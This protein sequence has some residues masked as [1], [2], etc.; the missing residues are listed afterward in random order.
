MTDYYE[1][2]AR[3]VLHLEGAV[4]NGRT[5]LL[6]EL[7]GAAALSPYHF[8][9]IWRLATGE[10]LG[11]TIRRVRLGH[12]LP[13]LPKR[14]LA[15]ATDRSGYATAQSY[16]RALRSVGAGSPSALRIDDDARSAL[17]RKL[18]VPD[19]AGGSVRVEIRSF[20][21]LQLVSVRRVGPY[22]EANDGFDKAFS[23]VLEHCKP[24]AITGLY[25][26]PHDD[27]ESVPRQ[28]RR[29][30]CALAL[31]RSLPDNAGLEP[32]SLP[33][34]RCLAMDHAGSYDR[35]F[36]RL[37]ALYRAALDDGL[38]LSDEPPVLQF[39]DDPDEVT[40]ADLRSVAMLFLV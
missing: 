20:D 14:N 4:K 6:D 12:S 13:A 17:G 33:G 36:G 1:R 39:H 3:A 32:V 38:A 37:D 15:T 24:D 5:P 31:S 23:A 40:E 21:P 18:S 30:D 28:D 29:M 10:K 2:I 26:R 25:G 19:G 9:R 8:H 7:A 34:G 22:E 27:P 16:A 11:D 35:L